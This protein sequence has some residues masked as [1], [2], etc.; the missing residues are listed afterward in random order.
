MVEAKTH[1][2][3]IHKDYASQEYCKLNFHI[4]CFWNKLH[5]LHKY[6]YFIYLNY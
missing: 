2:F 6:Q 4:S 5:V 1:I 3:N